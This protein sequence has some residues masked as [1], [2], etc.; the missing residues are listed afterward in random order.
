MPY[1]YTSMEGDVEQGITFTNHHRPWT[2]EMPDS[3]GTP[4]KFTVKKTVSGEAEQDKAFDIT[5]KFTYSNGTTYEETISIKASDEEPTLFDYVPI[6]TKVEITEAADGY[7]MTCTVD[8]TA[9]VE[10]T[11]EDEDA[12]EVVVNNHKD[13]E[14]PPTPPSNPQNP[15]NPQ[16]PSSPTTPT[17]PTNPSTPTAKNQPKTGDEANIVGWIVLMGVSALSVIGAG[18]RRKKETK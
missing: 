18:L 10:F 14:T 1:Y 9:G 4:G 5:V 6:G 8:G 3:P 12:V 11:V 17:S 16:N 2:P 15:Q 13:K 7:T